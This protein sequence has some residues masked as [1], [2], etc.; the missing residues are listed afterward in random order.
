MIATSSSSSWNRIVWGAR[1]GPAFSGRLF[2]R[3]RIPRRS[4]F[5]IAEQK[6][7][8][9]LHQFSRQDHLSA[10][11]LYFRPRNGNLVTLGEAHAHLFFKRFGAH[12]DVNFFLAVLD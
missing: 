5:G 8:F 3:S 2:P 1:R 9:A 4:A 7:V 12:I 11:V 10:F 6:R